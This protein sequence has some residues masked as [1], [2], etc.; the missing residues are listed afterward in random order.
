MIGRA[1]TLSKR[2]Q[3]QLAFLR[4]DRFYRT[5]RTAIRCGAVG[6]AFLCLYWTAASP[7]KRRHSR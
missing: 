6:F 5:L 7:G 2:N 4:V 1:S 3:A